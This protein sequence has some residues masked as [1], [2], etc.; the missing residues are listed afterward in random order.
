MGAGWMLTCKC[1]EKPKGEYLKLPMHLTNTRKSICYIYIYKATYLFCNSLFYVTV[2]TLV[3]EE[4]TC[5]VA[6]NIPN[7]CFNTENE[8]MENDCEASGGRFTVKPGAYRCDCPP[9]G[10]ELKT[11]TESAISGG[12]LYK[13]EISKCDKMT[14]IYYTL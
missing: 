10:N 7:S 6:P 11:T 8:N 3:C 4:R 1:P 13:M 12:G 2:Q 9:F 14:V 5:I